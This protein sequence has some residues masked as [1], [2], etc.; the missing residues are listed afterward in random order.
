MIEVWSNSHTIT[1]LSNE[2]IS[3]SY[4]HNQ[5]LV[6]RKLTLQV[7][8]SFTDIYVF[9]LF[10]FDPFKSSTALIY[11]TV[12]EKWF[13]LKYLIYRQSN[14]WQNKYKLCL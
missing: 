1:N 2:V 4:S 5:H 9:S 13:D 3:L 14:K 6:A 8:T 12:K 7:T 11:H 10:P